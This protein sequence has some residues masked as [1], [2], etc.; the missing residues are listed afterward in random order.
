MKNLYLLLITVSLFAT[1]L[2]KPLPQAL[3][4]N[5]EKALLGQKLFFDARLSK[6]GSISCATCHNIQT[7]GADGLP[8]SFGVGGAKGGIN[9]PTV[10]NSA[11][12]FAQFWDGRAKDLKTQAGGPI[13]NPVE[14]AEK[15]E[16]VVKKLSTD[17][18]YQEEFKKLY[19]GVT[20]D[21]IT[22]AIAEYEKTLITPNSRFDKYLRGDKS[23]LG[24]KEVEGYE[25]FRRKG[26][27]SCHNGI[28]IGGNMF[29]RFGAFSPRVGDNLGRFN[30]TKNEKDKY[31]FKVPSLRNIEL[32]AP[33]FHDA[34]APDL[35]AAIKDMAK[36][37][38]GKPITD[39]ELVRLE[40]FLKS[41]TGEKPK[42]LK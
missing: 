26:C 41:L 20:K 9:A 3:P 33:Y 23:A 6:D 2:I 42:A 40:A 8:L 1:D 22:D 27:V 18:A 14:M 28:N 34:S 15:F 10:F 32:T 35:K 38:L 37:Q 21:A 25:I 31:F 13:E 16:N 39:D 4:Y 30:V 7:S 29:Q 19:G 36:Y 5:K 24:Q 11:F 17:K 12:N